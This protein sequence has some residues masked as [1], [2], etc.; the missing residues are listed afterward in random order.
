MRKLQTL[1]VFNALRIIKKAGLKEQLL[2][3]MKEMVQKGKS[4]EDLGIASILTLIEILT[5]RKAEQAIYDVL[6]CPFETTADKVAEMDLEILAE[7][8][9]T[10]TKENNLSRFFTALAG[11]ITKK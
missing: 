5:E 1:D 7:N 11:M 9:E 8:L 6:S 4:V 3:Y 10:L 2:P